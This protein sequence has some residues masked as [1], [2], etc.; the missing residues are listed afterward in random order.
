MRDPLAQFRKHPPGSSMDETTDSDGYVAFGAK[1]KV[2]RLKIRCVVPPTRAP[3]YAYLLD[4]AYDGDSGTCL[5][6]VYT[7]L[8]V[9]VRG[10]NLLPVVMAVETGTADYIQEF[11]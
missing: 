8:L 2:E 9:T 11:D 10:K 5:M 1:D 6:L 7:F 3:G 4:V